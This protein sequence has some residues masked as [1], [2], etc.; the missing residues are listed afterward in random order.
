MTRA[1]NAALGYVEKMQNGKHGGFGYLSG[2]APA[3]GT[4]STMPGG[5]V[6]GLRMWGKENSSAVRRGA[7]YILENSKF[8]YGGTDS[9]LYAHYY[10]S[11][12]MMN[13]GG[14]EWKTYN[15]M[16][17]DQL[18]GRQDAKGSWKPNGGK[19]LEEHYRNCLNILMLEVYYRFLPTTG[20]K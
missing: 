15:A 11:Q 14:S 18:I 3:G 17:R 8:D 19:Q 2:N 10:E 9:D 7:K 16:F 4:Y 12:A 20:A 6:L 13:R 5:G 1:K